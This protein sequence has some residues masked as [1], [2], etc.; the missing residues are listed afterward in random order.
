MQKY[1]TEYTATLQREEVIP[2]PVHEEVEVETEVVAEATR[3]ACADVQKPL[4]QNQIVKS[5]RKFASCDY[6]N[7]AKYENYCWSQT[8]KDLELHIM[9]PAEVKSAKH[10]KVDL[11]P[12]YI[13]VE[14]LIPTVK[15]LVSGE[16][17]SKFKH[18]EAVWTIND[19]I[20]VLSLGKNWLKSA[21]KF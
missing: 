12:S 13:V 7:G 5:I 11:K 1:E 8:T 6:R 10:V 9:L 21:V 15:Q 3:E 2:P 14:S 18:N 4:V 17:W 20:L 16:T 19:G